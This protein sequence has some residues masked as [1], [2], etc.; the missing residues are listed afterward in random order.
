[1]MV[2]RSNLLILDVIYLICMLV[3]TIVSFTLF[4][5][6]L[7]SLSFWMNLV[8]SYVAITAI[9]IYARFIMQNM[10]RFKRFVPGYT[11]LGVV[12]VS[13]LICVMIYTLLTGSADHALRWFVL[14]HTVT[15]AIATI[16]CG[17]IMIYIHSLRSHEANEHTKIED[18]HLIEKALQQLLHTMMQHTVLTVEEERKT[19]QSLIELV[20]YSDPITPD[21]LE[22]NDRQILMDIELMNSELANQYE[23]G[24]LVNS[25]RI[26]S[27]LS[28]LRF[29]LKERNQQILISKS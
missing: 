25:E 5:H 7:L 8:A 22:K 19:V 13:Y 2:K 17:I 3:S 15:F 20:K 1:M 21:S 6:A 11:A 24:E 29:R 27:Q 4:N 28:Q 23:A 16:L 12:L 10:D 18:L 26:A 14:L 9:W